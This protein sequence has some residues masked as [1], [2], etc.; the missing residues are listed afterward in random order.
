VLEI[1]VGTLDG[2]NGAALMVEPAF[3]LL[4]CSS[5]AISKMTVLLWLYKR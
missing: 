3:K 1:F 4:C 5:C 2:S